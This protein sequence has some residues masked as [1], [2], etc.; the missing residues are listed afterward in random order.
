M[1]LKNESIKL[2]DIHL[3][4]IER[5]ARTIKLVVS[6]LSILTGVIYSF[7][8]FIYQS[9]ENA[10]QIDELKHELREQKEVHKTLESK[11]LQNQ[12]DFQLTATKLDVS[13]V[14]ISADLQFIKE[15]L[16]KR[17]MDK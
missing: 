1:K 2:D 16:M 8:I 15:Q 11:I 17:G 10:R 14:K 5:N 3:D 13:L 7:C 12:K 9:H 4:K 6:L